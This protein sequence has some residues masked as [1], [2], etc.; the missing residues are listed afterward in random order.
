MIMESQFSKELLQQIESSG[1][2]AVLVVD[3]V[4]H[5]VPLARALQAGG[6][7]TME[8]TLR[9]PAAMDALKAIRAEVPDMLAGIG[10]IL[11]T[12]QVRE[13]AQSG[14][15]FGVAPGMNPT[16]IKEAQQVGL[17]FA[18]GVVT[19]S[20]IEAAIELGCRELKFFPAEPS[21]GIA[22][23]KS[24]VAPYQHLG[25]SFFPLGG[26]NETNMASYLSEPSVLGIG[27]SW[28]A[29]RKLI[30]EE[31]WAAITDNAAK[32]TAIVKQIRGE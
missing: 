32:A 6:I 19:P 23:L 24:M 31:N 1:V 5:A 17:P 25:I 26:L 28:L 18:P 3:E 14:A 20:D 10:T 27:G 12:Q 30:Q 4:R 9:T 22:Y 15:A 7:H 13:V 11:T 2:I 16:V 8:L 21:G 29:T